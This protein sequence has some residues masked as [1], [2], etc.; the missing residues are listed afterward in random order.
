[1][2]VLILSIV[3]LS[4]VQCAK[5]QSKS[6]A[7]IPID[8]TLTEKKDTTTVI[9]KEIDRIESIENRTKILQRLNQ[10]IKNKEPDS[11]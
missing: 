5:T 7:S 3:F 11:S 8:K 4:F 1:M 9:E 2:R 6:P 10:K